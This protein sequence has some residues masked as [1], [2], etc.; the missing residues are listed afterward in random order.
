MKN[1]KST[2]NIN[3]RTS[4][5]QEVDSFTYLDM[6]AQISKARITFK[7]LNKVWS[8]REVKIDK[9]NLKFPTKLSGR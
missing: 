3:L 2:Q 9:K 4:I 1:T 6:Q 5:T 8:S 7:P